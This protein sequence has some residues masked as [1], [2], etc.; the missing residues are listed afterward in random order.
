MVDPSEEE[1]KRLTMSLAWRRL[2][3]YCQTQLPYG[4]LSIRVVNAEPTV[5]IDVRPSVRFDIPLT[6]YPR[7]MESR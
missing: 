6:S 1:L 5:L 4:E 3:A 7:D 2:I